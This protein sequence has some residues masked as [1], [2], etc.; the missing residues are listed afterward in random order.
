MRRGSVPSQYKHTV[1]FRQH[2]AAK[3]LIQVFVSEQ[4]AS[5][6]RCPGMQ[7]KSIGTYPFYLLKLCV[8]ALEVFCQITPATS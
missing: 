1:R 3:D 5:V 7:E 2:S 8:T 6:Q 4:V